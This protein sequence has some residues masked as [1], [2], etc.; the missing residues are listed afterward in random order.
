MRA[1]KRTHKEVQKVFSKPITFPVAG[2]ILGVSR[3]RA[4]QIADEHNIDQI[5]PPPKQ[6]R[7]MMIELRDE[8]STLYGLNLSPKDLNYIFRKRVVMRDFEYR[9]RTKAVTKLRFFGFTT[10]EIAKFLHVPG[11]TVKNCI[12]T[13]K[14]D[15]EDTQRRYNFSLLQRVELRRVQFERAKRELARFD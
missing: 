8:S 15:G 13:A 12:R 3:Q 11:V 2:E 9:C 14:R 5:S 10:D 7:Q 1:S 4:K 6:Q